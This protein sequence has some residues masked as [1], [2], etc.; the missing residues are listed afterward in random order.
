[1]TYRARLF[2]LANVHVCMLP[3][4]EYV[5]TVPGENYKH[6]KERQSPE[7]KMID[8][9]MRCVCV[10]VCVRCGLPIHK[11]LWDRGDVICNVMLNVWS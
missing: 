9:V 8:K 6:D 7:E 1:M 4:V 10:Y 2:A 3:A 11:A 5:K